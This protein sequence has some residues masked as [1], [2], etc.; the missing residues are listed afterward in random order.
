MLA[1]VSE[2]KLKEAFKQSHFS[3]KDAA[4]GVKSGAI[5][6]VRNPNGGFYSSPKSNQRVELDKILDEFAHLKV[7]RD[8]YDIKYRRVP[9]EEHTFSTKGMYEVG[10]LT[11]RSTLGH[12]N[13]VSK[14][15]L[16][17]DKRD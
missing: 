17:K 10:G 15:V 13:N 11:Y 8:K 16:D 12:R 1:E 6:I 9:R 4:R 5:K 14:Q 2:A 7:Q 3:R